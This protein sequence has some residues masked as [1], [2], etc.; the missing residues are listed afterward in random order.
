[1]NKIDEP[2]A[3]AEGTIVTDKPSMTLVKAGKLSTGQTMDV[4]LPQETPA[5]YRR[6]SKKRR[7]WAKEHRRSSQDRIEA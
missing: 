4:V 6:R 3:H 7:K 5:E 2:W 1:M